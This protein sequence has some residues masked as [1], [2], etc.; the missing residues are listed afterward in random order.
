MSTE[1]PKTPIRTVQVS[2][3]AKAKVAE[4]Q[5]EYRRTYGEEISKASV[6][7]ACIMAGN[8]DCLPVPALTAAQA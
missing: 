5:R 1:N 3:D 2:E 8:I 7:E 6:A 4:L